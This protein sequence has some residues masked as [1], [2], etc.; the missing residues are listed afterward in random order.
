MDI[1]KTVKKL[2]ISTFVILAL[3]LSAKPS[4]AKKI[5]LR[6]NFG[7][8]WELKGGKIDK[9]PYSARYI[10]PAGFCELPGYATAVTDST[11]VQVSFVHT[12]TDLCQ[13]VMYQIHGDELFNGIGNFDFLADGTVEGP[14]TMTNISCN[15]LPINTLPAREAESTPPAL[16][17]KE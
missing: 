14:L 9:K 10:I 8:I 15:S 11:G 1:R 13:A 12:Q 4:F 2:I 3:V 16:M 17:K 6:D 7:G 5:C